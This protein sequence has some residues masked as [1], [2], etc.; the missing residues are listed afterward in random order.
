[1]KLPLSSSIAVIRHHM[2]CWNYMPSFKCD[3]VVKCIHNVSE[4]GFMYH[5]NAE[6]LSPF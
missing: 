2:T 3:C 5:V 1:M 6:E 4:T